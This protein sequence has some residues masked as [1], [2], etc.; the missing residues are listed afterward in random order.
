MVKSFVLTITAVIILGR[1]IIGQEEL[2]RTDKFSDVNNSNPGVVYVDVKHN[3]YDYLERL[4]LK[5]LIQFHDEVKP[6][7]R[8]QLAKLLS[9]VSL[10]T[11]LL[12]KLEKDELEWY[13]QEF[14]NELGLD[15]KNERWFAYSYTD[16]VFSF[17]W[18]PIVAYGINRNYEISGFERWWGATAYAG[19]SDWFGLS[20][21]MRD[22]GELGSNV[23]KTKKFTPKTGHTIYGVAN[24]VEYSDVRGS[25]NFS[26][27]WGELSFQKD[28]FT[29]G[30]GKF[31]QLIHSTK[32]PSYP[33]IR[34]DLHPVDWLRFYYVHGWLNSN[35]IDSIGIYYR[36][37]PFQ[38][39]NGQQFVKKNI[40]MNLLTITPYEWLDLSI[41]NS[42][43]Y[44][45]DVRPEMML[46]FLFFKYLDRDV[47]K[48]SIED[49]NG[50]LHS[51]FVVRLP[52]TFKFYGTFFL[53]VTE[54]RNVLSNRWYN[55]WFGFTLGGKKVDL[56]VP[57]L[58]ITVE[59]TRVSPWVYEHRDS[60]MSYKHIDFI[61]G[62]WIG[63]NADLLRMQF[64]YSFLRG[65]KFSLYGELVRKG[66]LKSIT[67][68]YGSKEYQPFLYGP[69]RKDFRTGLDVS[70]EIIHDAFVRGY[71]EYSSIKDEDKSRTPL[72]QLG[73]K[74]S[75]GIDLSY[76]L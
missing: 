37:D 4:T 73:S 29:W 22:R 41:G 63:Q 51:D 67:V 70:Y 15:K 46:P 13:N 18:N 66:G 6:H 9:Q 7:T 2:S 8:A 58:D 69:V 49:G 59:Y 5:G 16:S 11:E 75:F 68:A 54:L 31:G 26:W 28:Y 32:A 35:F 72:W 17:R 47:G 61:L 36:S 64:D 76:G 56:V 38:S 12:N 71:Y 20:V 48:G 19:Y 65:L 33:F 53:D 57:N 21:N 42:S 23:D 50:Q 24:G 55:T 3:I 52:K 27:G 40:A 39:K 60:A 45:G 44:K 14:A 30:H 34:F 62:H 74:H 10:K 25:L 1:P 43:V